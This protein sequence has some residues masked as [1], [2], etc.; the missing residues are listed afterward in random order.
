MRMHFM[1]LLLVGLVGVPAYGGYK[2]SS[3]YYDLQAELGVGMP[4][5]AGVA[6]GQ[7]EAREINGSTGPYRPSSLDAQLSSQTYHYKT[8][9]GST[10]ASSHATVVAKNY[11]GTLSMTP[12]ISD[13][14][15]WGATSWL[16]TSAGLKGAGNKPSSHSMIRVLNHSWVGVNNGSS[17]RDWL[18]RSDY[19]VNRD[20]VFMVVGMHNTTSAKVSLMAGGYNSIAVGLTSGVHSTG[21]VYH[22]QRS[23][24]DIVVDGLS[25][26]SYATPVVSSAA[27]MLMEVADGDAGLVN[28]RREHESMKAILMAG[29]TKQEF[30]SWSHTDTRPLDAKFG[31][32]ELNVFNSYHILT[33]G[34]Q[35]ASGLD[36]VETTGWDFDTDASGVGSSY[37]YFDVED[38]KVLTELSA[39]LTWNRVVDHAVPGSQKWT[40]ANTGTVADDIA[41]LDLH[42]Y[43][44]D[45][46][47][48]D[49]GAQLE[50][51]MSTI[52]NVEHIY[53]N[54]AEGL[55][56]GRYAFEVEVLDAVVGTEYGFAWRSEIG[57]DFVDPDGDGDLDSADLALVMAHFGETGVVG[58]L[59]G[60]LDNDGVVGLSDLFFVRNHLGKSV[61][62]AI[63]GEW[64]GN[65]DVV[66]IPEPSGFLLLLA[67][68][69]AGVL[70][71]K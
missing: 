14:Y 62:D 8:T 53:L 44:V 23:R 60:D 39:I 34:E 66:L 48:M 4:S 61:G 11:Y 52:D 15:I 13:V 71:R 26:T 50:T 18:L 20:G 30:S 54:G 67:M 17:E 10:G 68:G 42:L 47:T 6:V 7:A 51:S 5:G 2:S 27:A 57:L 31:A 1:T 29:A 55:T 37:Y 9:S 69:G 58:E 38:N 45:A 33:A 64:N 70:R 25:G 35:D 46:G 21:T 65:G 49:L 56:A 32:G 3:G 28:A 59:I 63:G 41:N 22:H 24:P 43:A 19:M 12:D 16:N 40:N 36:L